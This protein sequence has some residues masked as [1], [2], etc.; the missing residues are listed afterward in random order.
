MSE[1]TSTREGFQRAMDWSLNG[2]PGKANEFAEATTLPT[3]YQVMNGQ[4]LEYDVYVKGVDE[5]RAKISEYKPKV[6][7]FL[8]RHTGDVCS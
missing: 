2:P 7:V 8:S 3:F 4:K 6:Y 1:Y 5:W